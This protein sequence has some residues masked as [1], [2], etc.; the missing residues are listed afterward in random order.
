MISINSYTTTIFPLMAFG[1][2][3][4]DTV[5]K[6]TNRD[7]PGQS[8]GARPP[9]KEEYKDSKGKKNEESGKNQDVPVTNVISDEK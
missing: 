6:G 8:E 5:D 4:G 7:T 3:K 9:K 1:K 2:K